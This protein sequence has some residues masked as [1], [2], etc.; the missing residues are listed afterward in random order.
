LSPALKEPGRDRPGSFVDRINRTLARKPKF[1][2][3]QWSDPPAA[4]TEAILPA[5]QKGLSG[6]A[7]RTTGV[8]V[9]SWVAATMNDTGIALEVEDDPL[10]I[11]IEALTSIIVA[12]TGARGLL[13]TAPVCD[14]DFKLALTAVRDAA[15]TVR[16][17]LVAIELARAGG[18]P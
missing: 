1:T 7:R 17:I 8:W 18:K 2:S 14:S 3:H 6:K 11:A 12:L 10:T 9:A 16:I 5:R 13:Q 4:A 15:A